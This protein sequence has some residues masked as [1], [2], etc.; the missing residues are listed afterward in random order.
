M[1]GEAVARRDRLARSTLLL[2]GL[3]L[4]VINGQNLQ[5]P[6]LG[7][8]LINLPGIIP[9]LVIA[10]SLAFAF[11]CIAFFNEQC[12]QALISVMNDRRARAADA[13][14]LTASDVFQEWIVKL[15]A[16]RMNHATFDFF[17]PGKAYVRTFST[18]LIWMTVTV[19]LLVFI[20]FGVIAAGAKA[21]TVRSGWDVWTMGPIAFAAMA[22]IAGLFVAASSNMDFH[23][24]ERA[25]LSR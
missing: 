20:H 8:E 15:Y 2:D 13:D 21:M 18:V 6:G 24:S 1:Y 9:A 25:G 23:F 3:L 22:N 4:M 16:S 10:A 5:I 17:E 7:V 19:V 14:F 11:L 12:Y